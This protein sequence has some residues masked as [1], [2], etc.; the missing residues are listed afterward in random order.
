MYFLKDI[1]ANRKALN[2]KEYKELYPCH[3]C[4]EDALYRISKDLF[5]CSCCEVRYIGFGEAKY[6]KLLKEGVIVEE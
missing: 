5:L 3:N 2:V 6:K 4:K 1:E